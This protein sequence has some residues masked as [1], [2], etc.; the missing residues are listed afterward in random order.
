MTGPAGRSKQEVG[1][2]LANTGAVAALALLSG[3]LAVVGAFYSVRPIGIA[4]AVVGNLAVA[5]GGAWAARNRFVPAATGSVWVLIVLVLAGSG[6]GHDTV[7]PDSVPGRGHVGLYFLVSGVIA[8]AV[9]VGLATS[10][11]WGEWTA[12]RP[13]P[14]GAGAALHPDGGAA[15]DSERDAARPRP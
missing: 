5:L 11:R 3:V 9:A 10:R 2:T 4:I 15:D 1:A 8:V 13:R 14:E 12:P 7:V 6:P